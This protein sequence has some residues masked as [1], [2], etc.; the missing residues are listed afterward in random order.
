MA[1]LQLGFLLDPE[2]GERGAEPFTV[3]SADLTTHGVIVGM[4]GS[5]KTGLGIV[6]LE[7]GARRRDPGA[8]PRPQGRHGQPPARLPGAGA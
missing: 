2:T 8:R 7:G 5:G 1:D 4:T 3:D 6:L